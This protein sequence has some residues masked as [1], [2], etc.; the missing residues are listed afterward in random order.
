MKNHLTITQAAKICNYERS[1]FYKIIAK[2]NITIKK[3]YV[4]K[5]SYIDAA[6]LCRVIPA[7]SL[8]M[9]LLNELI[10]NT[11]TQQDNNATPQETT[12][13]NS[14]D[15]EV[16]ELLKKQVAFL[17]K[18]LEISQSQVTNLLETVSKQTLLLENKQQQDN[19]TNTHKTT[20]EYKPLIDELRKSKK[21]KKKGK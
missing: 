14:A 21:K 16:I 19:N 15:N 7:E 10:D 4:S 8:N 17:E 12:A 20:A 5:K 13:Q 18:Q 11:S 3:D 6:E 2:Y 9:K 1:Y